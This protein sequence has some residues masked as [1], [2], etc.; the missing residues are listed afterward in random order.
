MDVDFEERRLTRANEILFGGEEVMRIFILVGD[1]A[2]Y[3]SV[4][5]ALADGRIEPS[6][7]LLHGIVLGRV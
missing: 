1:A 6:G 7:K 2:M 3:L 5:S 4:L